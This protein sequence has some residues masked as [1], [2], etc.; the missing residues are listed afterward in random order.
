M[1]RLFVPFLLACLLPCAAAAAEPRSLGPGL[2]LVRFHDLSEAVPSVTGISIV[3]LR[4]ARGAADAKATALQQHLREAGPLRLVLYDVSP[5]PA[6]QAILA[7]RQPN[8]VTLAPEG[9]EPP[10]DIA[11]A[12]EPAVDRVA[13]DALEGGADLA[14]LADTNG[15]KR[16]FDEAA[17]VRARSRRQQP[18]PP[19]DAAQVA[20]EKEAEEEAPPADPLLQH[21][22]RLARGLQALGRG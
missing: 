7:G 5:A 1:P 17:L 20:R 12:V 3:D 6:L 16:R 4:Y 15:N 14:V 11:V 9:A 19:P 8:V 13:Y 10:P 18:V 21:A 22:V 2:T